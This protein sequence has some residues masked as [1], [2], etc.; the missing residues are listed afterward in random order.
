MR[1]RVR[2]IVAL[3]AVTAGIVS[4]GACTSGDSASPDATPVSVDVPDGSD[5]LVLFDLSLE[6]HHECEDEPGDVTMSIDAQAEPPVPMDG[7]DILEASVDL[8]DETMSGTFEL[9][10]G[11]DVASSPRYVVAIGPPDDLDGFEIH[12]EL[13]DEAAWGVSVQQIGDIEGARSLPTAEVIVEDGTVSWRAPVAEIPEP[14]PNQPVFYGSTA[15]LVDVDG[16]HLDRTGA[17]L[18]ADAEPVR[19]FDD[20]ILLGG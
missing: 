18:D 12:I 19:A 17:P 20:C 16:Q 3:L 15:A 14:L 13:V 1:E 10:A 9:A 6:G 4:V 11:P 7:V 5:E 2:A 8:D